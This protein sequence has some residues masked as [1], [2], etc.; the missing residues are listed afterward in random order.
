METH[1]CEPI[2]LSDV[3]RVAGLSSGE[4]CRRFRKH[5]AHK[6]S[7]YLNGIRIENAAV[8]LLVNDD[9]IKGV[10]YSCGFTSN[11]Y[12]TNVFKHKKGVTPSEWKEERLKI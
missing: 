12:F 6:F 5:T 8:M 11:A 2:K 9:S 4:F 7:E 1:F 3:A 10:A